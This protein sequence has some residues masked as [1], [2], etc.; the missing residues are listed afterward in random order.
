MAPIIKQ[1]IGMVVLVIL[2]TGCGMGSSAEEETAEPIEVQFGHTLSIN[3]P[4]QEGAEH[5][6]E[7]VEEETDGKYE[8]NIFPSGQ[9]ASGNQR[10]A[11][12]MLRQ[13][14]Y[15]VDIT[16]SLVW[17][18]FDEQ[19]NITA[20]PWLLT[21]WEEAQETIDGKGGEMLLDI[22]EGNGVTPASIGITGF[23]Q[24]LNN[25]HQIETPEDL[26]N[27]DMRI[28]NTPVYFDIYNHYGA[29]ALDMDFTEAFAGIQQ[30]AIDGMEA[31]EEVVLTGSFYE[32]LDYMSVNNYS[33]DFFFL[34]FSNDFYDQLPEEDKQIF[35][36]AGREATEYITDYS[37]EAN[38]EAL[39]ELKNELDVYEASEE[40]IAAFKDSALPIYD[41]YRNDF[42][43]EL[44]DAFNY[45]D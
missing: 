44:R 18:S 35:L 12:E 36:E 32:I 34:S 7:I 38:V 17:S 26:E 13:G 15:D 40:E 3:S 30:G 16:S 37:A 23:R 9:I 33:I 10:K 29:N 27:L 11:I 14:S 6:A 22:L 5:F 4:W 20:M 24:M 25:E 2:I 43:A 19:L 31:V 28:P 21:S 45:P 8:V 41:M 39:E 42:S 1:M